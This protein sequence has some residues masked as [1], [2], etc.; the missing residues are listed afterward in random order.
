MEAAFPLLKGRSAEVR[1]LAAVAL[2][3]DVYPKAIG[4]ISTPVRLATVLIDIE[5]DG[6]GYDQLLASL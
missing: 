1:A 2:G 4:N 3:S 5:K 6:G